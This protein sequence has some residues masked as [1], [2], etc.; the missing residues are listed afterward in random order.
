MIGQQH[1][2][3]KLSTNSRLCHTDYQFLIAPMRG[4]R[5]EEAQVYPTTYFIKWH[6]MFIWLACFLVCCV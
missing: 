3:Y 6:D 2:G 5:R 1:L 4:M